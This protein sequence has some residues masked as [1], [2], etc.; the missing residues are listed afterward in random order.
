MS[1]D[2]FGDIFGDIFRCPPPKTIPVADEIVYLNVEKTSKN[3]PDR[4]IVQRGKVR[5]G[6]SSDVTFNF[7]PPLVD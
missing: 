5:T 4:L 3:E 7:Q 2:I 1:E 6:S